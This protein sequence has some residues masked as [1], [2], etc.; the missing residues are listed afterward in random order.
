MRDFL[1]G[2]RRKVGLVFLGMALLLTMGWF[3]SMVYH[4]QLSTVI[5]GVLYWSES[6]NGSVLFLREVDGNQVKA[7]P[8]NYDMRDVWYQHSVRAIHDSSRRSFLPSPPW[9]YRDESTQ[10]RLSLGS[11][12]ATRFI[13]RAEVSNGQRRPRS[14]LVAACGYRDLILFLTM[15]ATVMILLPNYRSGKLPIVSSIDR[16]VS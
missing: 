6:V 10:W 5:G 1:H 11:A 16:A 9:T 12:S 7:Y 13:D 14:C 3:R 15:I 8:W 2:W 4:D